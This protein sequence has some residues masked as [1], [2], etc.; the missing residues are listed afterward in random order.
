MTDKPLLQRSSCPLH[1][2]CG[3]GCTFDPR[4]P[5]GQD[6]QVCCLLLS[7]M[8]TSETGIGANLS[9]AG[10]QLCGHRWTILEQTSLV[11]GAHAR[12]APLLSV[13]HTLL[14][15][16]SLC[17]LFLAGRPE[18]YFHSLSRISRPF[19]R[20]GPIGNDHLVELVAKHLPPRHTSSTSLYLCVLS[21]GQGRHCAGA[22]LSSLGASWLPL[23]TNALSSITSLAASS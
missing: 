21:P 12:S 10:V 8:S 7:V 3:S 23:T 2:C 20:C 9:K 5:Q 22:H 16:S 15:S 18:T 4:C 19:A 1:N 6:C 11:G 14:V 17:E 13:L